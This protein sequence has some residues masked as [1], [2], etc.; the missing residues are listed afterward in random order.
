MKV[1]DDLRQ[2][3]IVEQIISSG[4]S[5]PSNIAEDSN[6]STNGFFVFFEYL[7]GSASEK[8]MT[9]TFTSILNTQLAIIN[10]AENK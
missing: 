7:S 6:V 10:K 3:I 9:D 4:V 2:Y 5:I 8:S 1:I